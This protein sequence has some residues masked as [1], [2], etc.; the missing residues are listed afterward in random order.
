MDLTPEQLR[1]AFAFYPE[2]L[3]QRAVLMQGNGRFVH[4][5]RA[6]NALK[7]IRNKKVWMRKP[8][9]MND[10]SEIEHGFR[11]L[12]Y[13]FHEGEGGKR[14]KAALGAAFPDWTEK[15]LKP[16]DEW[17]GNYQR[18]SYVACV[19][20]HDPRDDDGGRLTMWRAYCP[21]GE[22]VALVLKSTPFTTIS[23]VLGAYSFPVSYRS[24]QE[25]DAFFGK[26]AENV[27]RETDFIKNYPEQDR[28]VALLHELFRF[29]MLCTKHHS[30]LDEREW[31]IVYSPDRDNRPAKH[32]SKSV[33]I[34]GGAP[35]PVYSIP[36]EELP[37]YDISIPSIL[38]RV[39]IGPSRFPEAVFESFVH[40]LGVAGVEEP[41][42][43]VF[44][45]GIPLR[46]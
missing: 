37:G 23:D 3:K 22:G 26:I 14:F 24:Q 44:Y 17:I 29:E 20:G 41:L 11:S 12:R 7:I 2:A 21:N 42:E 19:S 38:D 45:S 40:E 39:I 43:K 35:Q 28:I 13:M 10:Y 27:E 4:Y 34:I 18:N 36:L 5:T 16:F 30:F 33:E 6:E 32:L 1:L 25:V 9:W 8:Q 31:R 46:L 15:V